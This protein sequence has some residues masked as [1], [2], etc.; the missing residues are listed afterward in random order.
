MSQTLVVSPQATCQL[1]NGAYLTCQLEGNPFNLTAFAEKTKTFARLELCDKDPDFAAKHAG[2]ICQFKATNGTT[3]CGC[4]ELN[5]PKL[6]SAYSR[7]VIEFVLGL[8]RSQNTI[9]LTFFASGG[10]RNECDLISEILMELEKQNW[11]GDLN[12]QFVDPA[13]T[14]SKTHDVKNNS[15]HLQVNWGYVAGASAAGIFG[16]G[17]IAVGTQLKEPKQRNCCYITG[18]IALIVALG[19]STQIPANNTKNRDVKVLSIKEPYF[20][21]I[22]GTMRTLQQRLPPEIKMEVQYFPN[23]QVCMRDG[24]KM[25][26]IFGYDIGGKDPKTGRES[27]EDY[28]DLKKSMLNPHGSAILVG[29]EAPT[30]FEMGTPFFERARG[31]TGKIHRLDWTRI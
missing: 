10:L 30:P 21:A 25:D 26:G 18:A 17:C 23:A 14:L 5:N 11:A 1:R 31:P 24:R 28:R 22:Q 13:Y 20:K 3:S 8:A 15:D 27:I 16:L 2:G 9:T 19:L 4:P 7:S 12:I 29:K 6:K